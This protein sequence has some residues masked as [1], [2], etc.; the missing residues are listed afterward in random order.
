VS[1]R[2]RAGKRHDAQ[3]RVLALPSLVPH[4][5]RKRRNRKTQMHRSLVSKVQKPLVDYPKSDSE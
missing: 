5:A 2:R 4:T 3:A 1:E